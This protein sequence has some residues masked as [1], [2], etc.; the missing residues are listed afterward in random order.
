[1][2]HFTRWDGKG[3]GLGLDT[4]WRCRRNERKSPNGLARCWEGGLTAYSRYD[5]V[6]RPRTHTTLIEQ[7]R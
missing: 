2:R 5:E 6:V 3:G 4:S 7:R 1:M